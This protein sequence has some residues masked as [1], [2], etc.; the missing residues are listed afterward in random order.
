[1]TI[2]ENKARYREKNRE[3]LRKKGREYARKNRGRHNETRKQWRK[4]NPEKIKSEK[5]KSRFKISIEDY[6]GMLVSQDNCCGICSTV[7]DPSDDRNQPCV[8]HDHIS[9]NIRGLLC[10]IC[11]SGLG[12][13]QDNGNILTRAV[14]WLEGRSV[15]VKKH[16]CG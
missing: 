6:R 5:L 8:D 4:N 9:K 7:F 3:V 14:E 16:S 1:M 11:N 13:F 10:R 12:G 15:F 2:K